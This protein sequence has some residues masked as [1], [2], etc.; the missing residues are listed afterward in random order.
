MT[1][2][3]KIEDSDYEIHQMKGNLF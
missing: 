2:Y 3:A 1:V